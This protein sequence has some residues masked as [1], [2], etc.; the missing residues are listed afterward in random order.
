MNKMRRP[1]ARTRPLPGTKQP[2]LPSRR[3]LQTRSFIHG[4]WCGVLT[5]W[6]CAETAPSQSRPQPHQPTEL[7]AEQV[8]DMEHIHKGTGS[9]K[10]R[11]AFMAKGER[12][13]GRGGVL[14]SGGVSLSKDEAEAC[15]GKGT[16]G[17][18]RC[19]MS[20]YILA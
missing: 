12:L 19:R 6:G 2:A 5:L 8:T 18:K 10:D 3:L 1:G 7:E 13:R 17:R 16:E 4:W 15:G 9:R 20:R 14:G 11:E